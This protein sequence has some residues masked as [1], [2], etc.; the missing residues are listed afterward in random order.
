[1]LGNGGEVGRIV[2]MREAV[3][4]DALMKRFHGQSSFLIRTFFYAYV[5]M[6]IAFEDLSYV[7]YGA[8]LAFLLLGGRFVSVALSSIKDPVLSAHRNVMTTMLP[9]GLAAAILAQLP[10][11]Y[12]L[13]NASIY[14]NIIVSVIIFTVIITVAGAFYSR[15]SKRLSEEKAVVEPE[16]HES[17]S[18]PTIG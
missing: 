6:I 9:R 11:I 13:P 2:R 1:M 4:A 5:G 15:G 3:G 17:G 7:G 18:Q 10:L 8:V 14:P 12:G 16:A